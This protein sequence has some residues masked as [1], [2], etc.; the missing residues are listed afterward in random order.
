VSDVV[1]PTPMNG[2]P[3]PPSPPR[4]QAR[5]LP[6]SPRRP[7]PAPRAPRRRHRGRLL[8]ILLLALATVGAA[9]YLVTNRSS[10][11][12]A[13]SHDFVHTAERVA[14]TARSLP[15]AAQNVQRFTELHAFDVKTRVII[16]GMTLDV[17]RLRQLAAGVSGSARLIA[18]QAATAGDEA[19]AAARRYHDAVAFTY[20]LS[21]AEAARQDLEAA[22][23]T[24]D[25]Q[26][27]AWARR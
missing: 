3:S 20:R 2:R 16:D 24:L 23:A 12:T 6:P 21:N 13:T 22:A 9:G 15:A 7:R 25:Q 4:P 5:A 14:T 11:T 18:D 27:K 17:N 10:G 1:A 26:A 19:I 8:L